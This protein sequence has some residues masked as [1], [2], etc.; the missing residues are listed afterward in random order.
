MIKA[1][2][3]PIGKFMNVLRMFA[4]IAASTLLTTFPSL[5]LSAAP[6]QEG[7]LIP[8]STPERASYYLITTESDGEY[9]RTV[10]SR[11]SSSSHGYS[12]TRIDCTNRRYQDL[13]YG[14][15]LQSNIKMYNNVQWAALVSG[16][17][18]SDLVNFV[19]NRAR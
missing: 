9:L 15:D 12:V 17:S 6:A 5:Q 3:N 14:E 11:I 1:L 7:E 19:C 13:G 4:F 8:R 10:H 2:A 16:S 18:K